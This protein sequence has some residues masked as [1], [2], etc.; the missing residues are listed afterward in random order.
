M[1]SSIFQTM[2]KPT[3]GATFLKPFFVSLYSWPHLLGK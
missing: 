2:G 1:L 3:R